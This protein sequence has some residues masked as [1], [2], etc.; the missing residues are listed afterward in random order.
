MHSKF[1][2]LCVHIISK[3]SVPVYKLSKK[4]KIYLIVMNKRSMTN[5]SW[6]IKNKIKDNKRR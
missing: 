6:N 3:R 5:K 4:I 2:V 1:F